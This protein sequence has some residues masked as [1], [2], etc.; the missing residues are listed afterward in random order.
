MPKL[1]PNFH[2]MNR[3]HFFS[4]L[5]VVIPLFTHLKKE[6]MCGVVVYLSQ[7]EFRNSINQNCGMG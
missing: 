4:F 1:F 5:V 2:K 7:L 6:E 3:R